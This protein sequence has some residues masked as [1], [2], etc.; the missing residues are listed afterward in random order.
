MITLFNLTKKIYFHRSLIK[1]MAIQEI[2]KR[3]AGTVAGFAWMIVQ[4]LAIILVFWFIFSV[5]FKIQPKNDVPF[6][7]LF[8]CAF[9]PWLTFSETLMANTSCITS[10]PHLV[11]KIVFPIEILVVVNLMASLIS[12]GFMLIILMIVLALNGIPVSVYNLQFI[13]YLLALMIFSTGLGWLFSSVN[14]FFRDTEQIIGVL[15]N[16]WFWMTPIVWYI[17][18]IPEQYRFIIKLNPMYYIV[19]GYRHSFIHHT[20]FLD[21]YRWAGY[22]WVMCAVVFVIGGLVFRKLKPEFADVL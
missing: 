5:G 2:Q 7:A 13:Y 15:I 19:E 6:V 17:E 18:M 14:V 22:F 4:P 8:F 20:Y 9:V 16:I 10:K 12:H 21:V 11:K 3:Y 1:R